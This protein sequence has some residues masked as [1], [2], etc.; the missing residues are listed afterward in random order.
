[1]S[2]KGIN[3]KINGR[4]F[5]TWVLANFKKFKLPEVFVAEGEDPCNIKT[6]LGLKEYQEFLGNYLT[7]KSPI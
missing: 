2:N 1:M 4:L 7:L 3:L 5:P 6:K